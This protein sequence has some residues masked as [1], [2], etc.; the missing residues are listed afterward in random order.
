MNKLIITLSAMCVSLITLAQSPQLLNYQAVARNSG[1]Q[2]VTNQAIGLRFSV[3]QGSAAGTTIYQ[4]TQTTTTNAS[5]LFTVSIGGGTIVSGTMLGI[6]WKNGSKF[7][8]V[9]IDPAGGASYILSGTT[10]LLSVPYALYA[11]KTNLI[12]GNGISIT[13]GNTIVNTQNP[14]LL[15]GNTGTNSATNFLGT[16]DNQTLYFRTNNLNRVSVDKEDATIA[17]NI[18]TVRVS[19]NPLF[20][21]QPGQLGVWGKDINGHSLPLGLFQS[22]KNM[23][24]GISEFNTMGRFLRMSQFRNDNTNYIF[25]DHGIAQD[26]SYYIAQLL[27]WSQGSVLPRKMITISGQNNVG[28]NMNMSEKPTANFH[29]K[30]TVRLEGLTQDNTQAN[31]LV[32]DNNGNLFTRSAS[33]ITSPAGWGL[34]GNAG[35]SSATNFLGTTDNQPLII[36]TN[37]KTRITVDKSTVYGTNDISYVSMSD[38]VSSVNNPIQLSVY[39]KDIAGYSLPFG[40]T[41]NVT[42]MTWG[43]ATGNTFGR[44]GRLSQAS[45]S[46]PSNY[47]FYDFGIGQDQ[48]Y[49]FTNM[50]NNLI[51]GL[52]PKKMLTITPQDYVGVNFLYNETPTANFH[53]K[54]TLRHEGLTTN[55][56]YTNIF[57]ADASGN[58]FLRDLNTINY[59]ATDANG[60]NYSGNV[61]VG[62]NSRND[63]KFS[64]ISNSTFAVDI[65]SNSLFETSVNLK[66]STNNRWFQ[67][68]VG[69]TGNNF[70]NYGVGDGNFGI[71]NANTTGLNT[72]FPIIITKD[73]KVG[74]GMGA[75]GSNNFPKSR[76]Q[77]KDGD[78]YIDQIGSGVIMKSPNGQCWRMTVND[79]GAPVFTA[80]TCPN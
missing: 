22:V 7:L 20:E 32:S 73:D 40:I 13:N 43:A 70:T 6:D 74:I 76:L 34:T 3:L 51:G 54:G 21:T 30:G 33:T 67:F 63:S 19:D 16:T 2:P 12:A 35:T 58:V 69:A 23:T 25:Y 1:G 47:Y 71:V 80:I 24:W 56:T 52:T 49:F 27:N 42:G 11:E 55:N 37:N 77:V 15:T 68:T 61:G 41:G 44:L 9:E 57:V 28:I 50:G 64:V 53:T 29:T 26:S 59:W 8:K 65:T 79:A 39:G 4:E 5:G 48:S 78:I 17:G 75:G 45:T 14:W 60:I 66:N 10:Q 18:G 62:G 46:N 38:P 72:T 31:V 36:K